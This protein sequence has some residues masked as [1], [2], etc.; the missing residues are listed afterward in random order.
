V[1]TTTGAGERTAGAEARP[2]RAPS[3]PEVVSTGARRR[4]DVANLLFGRKLRT[5]Q[6]AHERLANPIALAVFASDALSSVAYAT[7]E[8]L[9]VMVAA[10]VSAS[11]RYDA[12]LPLSAGIVVL[13]VTLVFSY[14]QTIKAYPSAGGAY[15]V[16]RDNFGVLPAQVA[17]VALL[18]DYIL[19]VAV[20]V[21]AGVAAVYSAFPSLYRYRVGIVVAL[22]WLLAYLNLRGVRESGRIFAVPTYLFVVSILGIVALGVVRA[23]LGD[24][25]PATTAAAVHTTS[26]AGAALG[27]WVLLHA[28]AS[29]STAMTGVEA[30]SNGVP[31]F[32]PVEWRN[33]RTVLMWLGGLLATMFLGISFLAWKLQPSVATH[34]TVLSQIADS[35]LGHSAAGKFGYF[36]V[37]AATM[38]ILV[39]AANTSFADFPRL[40]SFH[41]HDAFLP[42]PLTHRGRRLVFS[43]GIVLLAGFATLLVVLFGA[44]VHRLIPLYAIGVFTSFTLSQA[45]MARKHIREKEPGW[46]RGLAINGLGAVLSGIVGLVIAITKFTH[47]AWIVMLVV[48]V[49]VALLVRVNHHYDG[50]AH[51]L[52]HDPAVVPP[53]HRRL[54]MVVLVSHVDEG[55]DRAM[56]YVAAIAPDRARCIHFGPPSRSLAAAFWARHGRELESQ[57]APRGVVRAARRLVRAT[58]EEHPDRYLAVVVP[59]II[60]ESRWWHV[61]RHNRALRLKAG[62]LFERGVVVVN[63]PTVP[64][65]ETL[66][67]RS[68]RRHVVVVPVS[69]VH[70]GMNDAINFARMLQPS[71]MRAVHIADVVADAE[72][73]VDAWAD[74]EIPIPLE[75]YASPFRE[76]ASPLLE[77]VQDARD[78][79]ADI[80]TVVLG[81]VVPRW[82]QHGLH[83]HRALAIKRRLLFEPGVAVASVPHHL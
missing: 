15:I 78:D 44:N 21:S 54:D 16:T 56:A 57:P 40:A 61:I 55:L 35:I 43:N 20:S 6:E 50:V 64:N 36:V 25:H 46:R 71:E 63:I 24:L 49:T 81:E 13:L 14:R 18:T 69:G 70:A 74:A 31:A 28:Y 53:A 4:V 34:T 38:F 30:I 23:L 9:V 17:G 60:E 27:L 41:A 7:E 73:V 76:V 68:L 26:G 39:L 47:G 19:T 2:D 62:L 65:D 11:S 42:T 77:V 80:V 29:G 82:Y 58:H 59:E 5:E 45:G 32:K 48:P 51:R 33:A 10:G 52:A 8:M 3:P 37:Q 83:N 75:V 22:I 79:G 67:L 72:K 66:V 12:L 1:S